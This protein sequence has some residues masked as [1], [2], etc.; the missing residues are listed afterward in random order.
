MD[1]TDN[2]GDQRWPRRRGNAGKASLNRGIAALA[3]AVAGDLLGFVIPWVIGAPQ[4]SNGQL[5]GRVVFFPIGGIVS[6]MLAVFA[7]SIGRKVNRFIEN[8]S[9]LQRTRVG[10][11]TDLG[12]ERRRATTGIVLGVMSIVLNPLL[13]FA[14]IAIVRR[15]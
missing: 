15:G 5:V 1:D 9:D 13:A 3:V 7:I 10:S 6:L 14:L 11:F 8:L 12:K 4:S 2:Q